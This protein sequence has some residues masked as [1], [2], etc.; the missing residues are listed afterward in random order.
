[1]ERIC[2]EWLST[3]KSRWRQQSSNSDRTEKQ[4]INGTTVDTSDY[5]SQ[6]LSV[7]SFKVFN[8]DIH[9]PSWIQEDKK[10][11]EGRKKI[12]S[13]AQFIIVY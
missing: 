5:Y 13:L 11:K 6:R 8:C 10:G 1:M 9:E 12:Y 3:L 2:R 7:L 4:N